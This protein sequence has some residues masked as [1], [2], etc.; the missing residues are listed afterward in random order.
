MIAGVI[1][2]AGASSRLGTP[3]QLLPLDGRPLLQHVIDVAATVGLEPIVVVL[4]YRAADVE[5]ALRLPDDARIVDNPDYSEGQSSSL[6][7]GLA[8][9]EP[10]VGAAAILMGDQPRIRP[11]AIRDAVETYRRT[12]APVVRTHYRG[13]PGHP[14]VLD[15]SAWPALMAETKDRGARGVLAAH[16]EWVVPLDRDE[17]PPADI[18]TREDYDR[19]IGG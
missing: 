14:V 5:A 12:G 9:L 19:L 11:E 18:D 4:G 8:A 10:D 7:R 13:R 17:D 3:K 16:P 15:R 1:L 2:A 6:R